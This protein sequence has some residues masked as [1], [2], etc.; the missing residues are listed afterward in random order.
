MSRLKKAYL[1]NRE[2]VRL[3]AILVIWLIFMAFTQ[4]KKFYTGANFLTMAGQF[5]EYGMMVLGGMLCMITGG[6][7]LSVVGAA[8]ATSIIC[9]LL[10]IRIYG[11]EGSMNIAGYFLFFAVAVA[12][13]LIVGLANGLL[14]AK[15]KVPPIL[16]TLGIN[17]LLKGMSIVL[18][19]GAAI[20]KFPK[21]FCDAFAKN[22]GGVLPARV[23]VFIIAAIVVWFLLE[24]TTYGT[25]L[26]LY[27]T[28]AHVAQFSGINTTSLLL[29][30]YITSG[31]MASIGGLLML[32]DYASARADYGSD[33]TMKAILIMVLGGVSPNGGKGKLSGAVTALI[34][35]KLIESGIRR[36]RSVSDY[37]VTLIWGA[38]LLLALVLDY[39][40]TRPKKVKAAKG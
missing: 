31:I 39:L 9:A 4:S 2:V 12:V 40:S 11:A 14:V 38:V 23:I 3:L 25:K 22:I 18:T 33:Y 36:F 13:G 26:R 29:K 17:E 10:A 19:G 32:S 37:Y 8:N 16:A 15:V 5:P 1:S 30:T 7:D 21:E 27:G 20:S 24:R 35:L 28:S 6:I 34:L